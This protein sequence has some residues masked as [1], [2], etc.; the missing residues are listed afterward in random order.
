MTRRSQR[1]EGKG[2]R[3]KRWGE[4]QREKISAEVGKYGMKPQIDGIVS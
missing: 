1:Y 2:G 4:N 3:G